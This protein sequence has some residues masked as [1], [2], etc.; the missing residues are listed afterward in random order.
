MEEIVTVDPGAAAARGRGQAPGPT[1][2]IAI[3]IPV[4]D[5]PHRVAPL[6]ASIE[7]ASRF[8]PCYPVFLVSPGDD[9]EL[10]AIEAA[11][12]FDDEGEDNLFYLTVDWD[13]G[14]GDY[15]RKI[16]LGFEWAAKGSFEFVFL[17]ADDLSFRPG[18]AE[19]A[20]ACHLETRACVVGTN[21]AGNARV[22]RGDHSTH[23]LV[24]L[25]YLE[26]GTIDEPDSGRLLHE[27]YS[28]NF[29]DTEFVETAM[30]RETWAHATDS[31]VEHHHPIWG[32][33]P[34]DETYQKG[35]AD[36]GTDEARFQARRSLWE[37]L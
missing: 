10:D 36:Y 32:K 27:G 14:A 30:A 2:R 26:C 25:D 19:R 29:C 17:G 13:P 24:H 37:L 6:V 9:A 16:N 12:T 20:L 18:W 21:D 15:P 31:V 4:L 35:M 23:T 5:R 28:H 1:V 7:A 3:L 11:R 22:M 34:D 33:A 8:T